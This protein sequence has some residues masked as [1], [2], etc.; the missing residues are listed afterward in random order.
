MKE[1]TL[2]AVAEVVD[3]NITQCEQEQARA[4]IARIK[5]SWQAFWFELKDFH[6]N[7]RW[8]PL[9]YTSFKDCVE[10]ELGFSEQR[11]YQ[12]L[13]AARIRAELDTQHVLSIE[14]ATEGQLRELKPLL[15]EQR[16]EVAREIDFANTSVREVRE[17]VQQAKSPV[18]VSHNSGNNEWYTPRE[19]TDAAHRVM[20]GIDLDPAS[21]DVA[22][23]SINAARYYTAET[24]GLAQ[25]WHGRVWMNPPYAGELIGKFTEKLAQHFRAGNVSEAIVL[26]NNATETNWFQCLLAE[27]SAVCF[28][29]HRIRYLDNTGTAQLTGLQGQAVLYL[30]D[31]VDRFAQEFAQFGVILYG[32]PTA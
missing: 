15:P 30:G 24:D 31:A 21:S 27:A 13:D 11:A 17:I 14:R 6:D 7:R 16:L 19:Y 4:Q 28:V 2:L 12:F 10:C 8:L 9:G 26:V 25:H 5:G 20:G 22:N 29:K 1:E 3:G 32:R 18:H 23:R